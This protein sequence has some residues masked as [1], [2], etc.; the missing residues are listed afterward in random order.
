[1]GARA[2]RQC[3]LRTEPFCFR[4]AP[5][6]R[7][8]S[9]RPAP[10]PA[11]SGPRPPLGPPPPH[12]LAARRPQTPPRKV[13]LLAAQPKLQQPKEPKRLQPTPERLPLVVAPP[14]KARPKRNKRKA[15]EAAGRAMEAERAEAQVEQAAAAGDPVVKQEAAADEVNPQEAAAGDPEVKKAKR[16]KA[17]VE[18]AAASDPAEVKAELDPYETYKAYVHFALFAAVEAE[19]GAERR[20]VAETNSMRDW[21]VNQRHRMEQWAEQSEKMLAYYDKMRA[22]LDVDVERARMYRLEL[23]SRRSESY[24]MVVNVEPNQD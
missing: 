23:E 24:F 16:A 4:S 9:M 2:H 22:G 14:K 3:T 10:V 15:A 18:Q 12:L 7:R 20:R 8:S 11:A 5:P 13:A 19:R 21:F 6:A 17:Q 1:M